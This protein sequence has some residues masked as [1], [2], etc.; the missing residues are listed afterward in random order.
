MIVLVLGGA[1]SGK[2]AAAE[3]IAGKLRQPVTYLAT[4]TDAGSDPDLTSRIEAHRA[5]R[6][7]SWTTVQAE[8][9]LAA[10]VARLSGT[11]LLDSLGPWVALT[12]PDASSLDALARALANRDGDS[13]VV[14][15]EVGMS[16][17]PS[18]VLGREF[19]DELGSANAAVASV[20]DH[21]LLVVAGRVLRTESLDV[22]SLI[23]GGR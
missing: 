2:S 4:L 14:S 16:V 15:D 18:T 19:R 12:R 11:L 20:A 6:A 1:R 23:G 9:Q 3:V 17:H 21:V 8:H 7:A 10:H 13:V 5:R 22:A